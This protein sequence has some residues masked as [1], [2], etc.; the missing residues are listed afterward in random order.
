[1]T[2]IRIGDEKWTE[3]WETPEKSP[4]PL[5]V[6]VSHSMDDPNE[7][8]AQAGEVKEWSLSVW[9]SVGVSWVSGV[10]K[11]IKRQPRGRETEEAHGVVGLKAGEV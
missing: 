10:M 8:T 1:M 9:S 5:L 4:K 6:L 2:R 7:A 3:R 11:G